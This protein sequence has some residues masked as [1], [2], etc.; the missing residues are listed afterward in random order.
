[1]ARNLT[2][3]LLASGIWA[4]SSSPVETLPQTP[5][6]RTRV[7]HVRV[8]VVVTDKDDRLVTDLTAAD[9]EI[10]EKGRLQP[11]TDFEF[12]SVP[13]ADRTV[14]L[15]SKPLPPPDVASNERPAPSSR[16][17]VIMV[18]PVR[19]ADLV[20][21]KN[22]LT[23]M[24]S[25]LQPSDLVALTYTYRSDL[26]QDFTSDVGRLVQAANNATAAA[27]GFLAPRTLQVGFRN[28]IAALAAAPHSRKAIF[29]V[30]N[31]TSIQ[32]A[33]GSTVAKLGSG[34]D[35]LVEILEEARRVN[36]PIYSIDPH[37]LATPESVSNLGQI[38]TPGNREGIALNIQREH[39]FL[40][41]LAANTAGQAFVNQSNLSEA[42]RR[43]VA[44]NGSYY[45]LGYS[46]DPWVNDGQFHPIDVNVTRPGVRVRARAGYRTENKPPSV[47]ARPM[48]LVESL[49]DGVAGGDL[50]LRIAATPIAPT[51]KGAKTFLTLD[52]TYP[53][54][55][56]DRPRA[57]DRLQ[58]AWVALDPDARILASGEETLRVS[59]DRTGRAAFTLSVNQV[60]DVPRGKTVLRVAAASDLLATRGAVHL[61]LDVPR[62]TGEP[63]AVTPLVLAGRA[64]SAVRVA[65]I[66][67]SATALPLQPTTRR[68]FAAA[69]QVA[70]FAR[71]IGTSSGAV[72]GELRVR[73]G[74]AIVRMT[75]VSLVAVK[76][77]TDMQE[78]QGVLA[79]EGLAPGAY[80]LEISVEG[81]ANVAA[82]RST[83]ITIK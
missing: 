10:R 60:I 51:R 61:Q 63:L 13:L 39:D 31:G 49:R 79:L 54:L 22:V 35:E 33:P 56:A 6:F 7:N 26:G 68:A 37:G 81:A 64:D 77:E 52:V 78:C 17:V 44:D 9:F 53:A 73:Q 2:A 70:V 20:P 28:V 42:T 4:T 18:G 19:P 12:V 23:E 43:I 45:L 21:L 25:S 82:N 40:R 74:D 11:I 76:G 80:V 15:R 36:I 38:A 71:A 34:F 62:L 66:G 57:D 14:D 47:L 32:I 24:L 1:M 67:Q 83:V 30:S 16:A 48:R 69:E 55:D 59:L 8:D 58:L 75:P 27:G 41:L 29:Y 65:N 50:Q 46:P 3:L 72:K 5:T